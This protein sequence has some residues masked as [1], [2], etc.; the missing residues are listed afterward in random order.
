MKILLYESYPDNI[1]REK[2]ILEELGNSVYLFNPHKYNKKYNKIINKIITYLPSD[3]VYGELNN[4]LVRLVESQNFDMMLV[5]YGKEIYPETLS[6]IKTKIPL[7]VNWNGDELFN[8]LNNNQNILDSIAIYDFHCS[9]R[10]HLKDEYLSKGVKDFIEVDWYYKSILENPI[11]N[12]PLKTGN[13]IGSWS[14]KREKIVSSISDEEMLV[15]GWGWKKKSKCRNKIIGDILNEKSMNEVFTNSKISINILTE[16]NR[17]CINFRNYEI[18]SQYGF[19]I[20]ER[21]EKI[22]EIFEED[23]NIVCFDSLDELNDKYGFYIK[24][25]KARMNILNNGYNFVK[26]N[27]FDLKTQINKVLVQIQK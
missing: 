18:P 13:F 27:N 3:L 5:Y 4:N 1:S 9:P 14:P 17:D 8:K 24:N 6:F 7:V 26:N 16:E 21:S 22:L 20:S 15:Y 25:E 11:V 23:K 10:H 2:I 19:Q 12:Y